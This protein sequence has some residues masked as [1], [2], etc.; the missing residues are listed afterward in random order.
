M[1]LIL[2]VVDRG[3]AHSGT[4]VAEEEEEHTTPGNDVEAVER[5]QEAEGGAEP[6]PE[7]FESNGGGCC[8]REFGW[9]DVAG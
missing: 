4:S 9:W 1:S 5:D 8:P 6:F 2:G 3:V 7:G